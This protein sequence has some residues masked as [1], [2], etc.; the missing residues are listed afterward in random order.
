MDIIYS[1]KVAPEPDEGLV[2]TTGVGVGL[3][4]GHAKWVIPSR[5]PHPLPS[6]FS[7]GTGLGRRVFRRSGIL[8]NRVNE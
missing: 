5:L 1:V 6:S 3:P 8:Q 4:L 2:P 7:T